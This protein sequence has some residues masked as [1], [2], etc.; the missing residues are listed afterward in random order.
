MTRL[1][2]HVRFFGTTGAI[3]GWVWVWSVLFV[4]S[5]CGVRSGIAGVWRLR[6]VAVGWLPPGTFCCCLS[7][8][9]FDPSVVSRRNFNNNF[10]S[11]YDVATKHV[12]VPS[13]SAGPFDMQNGIYTVT[14]K[15]SSPLL[16]CWGLVLIF[17]SQLWRKNHKYTVLR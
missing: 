5:S 17:Y 6:F 7:R 10:G 2:T 4:P 11:L 9:P 15:R 13:I 14:E 16:V 8:V 3:I 1:K 12:P